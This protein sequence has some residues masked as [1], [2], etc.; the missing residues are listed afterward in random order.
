MTLIP[1][2]TLDW[3]IASLRDGR[4]YYRHAVVHTQDA[5]IRRAFEIAATERS[6][7]LAALKDVGMYTPSES[8]I[9]EERASEQVPAAH[10]YEDLRRQFDPGHPELQADALVPRESATLRLMESVFRSHPALVVRSVIKRHYLRMQQ[11]GA[12]IQRM[13]QRAHAA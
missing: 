7:L 4:T 2:D 10:R 9:E 13:A 6:A 3:L 11:A 8:T 12:I 5:E 1:Q